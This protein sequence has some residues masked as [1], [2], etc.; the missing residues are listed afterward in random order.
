VYAVLDKRDVVSN[1]G[2]SKVDLS[3]E[4]GLESS[5]T[6][7]PLGLGSI[8]NILDGFH[9]S[10]SQSSGGSDFFSLIDSTINNSLS[11]VSWILGIIGKR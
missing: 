7:G 5:G 8:V 9:L 1:R 4:W 11:E 2:V 3:R 6:C 10:I